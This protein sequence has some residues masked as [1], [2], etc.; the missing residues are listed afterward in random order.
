VYTGACAGLTLVSANIASVTN[1][2]IS[3]SVVVDSVSPVTY[4]VRVDSQ[5]GYEGS[6]DI[7]ISAS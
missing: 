6:Y 7:T 1:Q 4:Y 5:N 2:S 3:T